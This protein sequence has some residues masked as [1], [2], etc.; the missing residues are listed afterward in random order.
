MEDGRDA[1]FKPSGWGRPEPSGGRGRASMSE[2]R[3][4]ATPSLFTIGYEGRTIDELVDRL[5]AAG[6]ERVVDVRELPLSRRRPIAAGA[7]ADIATLVAVT[8]RSRIPERPRE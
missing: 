8:I 6:I 4:V 3:G 5:R 2:N 7:P 1:S